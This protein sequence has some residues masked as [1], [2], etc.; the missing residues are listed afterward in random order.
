MNKLTI[1]YIEGLVINEAYARNGKAIVCFLTLR[2]GFVVIGKSACVDPALFENQRGETLAK[3]DA[4]DQIW[5][6]EGYL[7]QD[8]LNKESGSM[9]QNT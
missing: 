8:R 7:L 6:L 2:N 4:I 3:S 1:E 9:K 5:E